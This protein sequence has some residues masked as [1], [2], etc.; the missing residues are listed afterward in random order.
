MKI[1]GRILFIPDAHIPYEDKEA[2][3]LMLKIA[4]GWD[5]THVVILGDWID[6]YSISSHDKDP[7]RKE[8]FEYEINSARKRLYELTKIV[9]NAQRYFMAGNHEH[10]L[11]RYI[12]KV[13]PELHGMLT[14]DGLLGLKQLGWKYTPYK[15]STTIGKAS[16]THDVG[17]AGPHAHTKAADVYGKNII[18]G[19]THRA[20]ISYQGTVAGNKHAGMMCG[21]LGDLGAIDYMH[22]DKARKDWIHGV[23]IG[24]LLDNGHVFLQFCP[25]ID[26][27]TVVDGELYE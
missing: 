17:Q 13:A 16:I 10:R 6:C 19:H 3:G 23:G 9:P 24:H 26:G 1:T 11:P 14:I 5:P 18:I 22:A 2:F 27:R 20:G 12:S 8:D 25:F 21:W 7:S 4:K 15:H